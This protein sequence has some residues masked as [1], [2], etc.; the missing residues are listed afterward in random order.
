MGWKPS[1]IT[2]VIKA[3]EH[4]TCTAHNRLVLKQNAAFLPACVHG[5]ISS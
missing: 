1:V 2:E 5:D 3:K 4:I